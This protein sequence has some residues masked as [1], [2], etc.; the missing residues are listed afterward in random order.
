M[1]F[2]I[3]K[4]KAKAKNKVWTRILKHCL[5]SSVSELFFSFK[6]VPSPYLKLF[7]TLTAVWLTLQYPHRLQISN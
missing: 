6:T 7:Y 4:M 1:H 3:I 5:Q 2:A